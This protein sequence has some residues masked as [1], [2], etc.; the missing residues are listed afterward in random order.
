MLFVNEIG[1]AIKTNCL[2][3]KV[4][5]VSFSRLSFMDSAMM[6]ITIYVISQMNHTKPLNKHTG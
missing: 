4:K 3:Q 2:D 6:D 5:W 1:H